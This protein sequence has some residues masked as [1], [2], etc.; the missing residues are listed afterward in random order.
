VRRNL[1]ASGNL[2]KVYAAQ[3]IT[4]IPHLEEKKDDGKSYHRV[5]RRWGNFTR[6][7]ALPCSVNADKAEAASKDG[8]LTITIP[9]SESARVRKLKI[10]S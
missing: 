7:V 10:K 8:V 9:K 5:E 2:L 4:S 1:C 3:K 6:T